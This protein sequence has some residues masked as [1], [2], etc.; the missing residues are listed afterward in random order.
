LSVLSLSFPPTPVAL[1]P[2]PFLL[3]KRNARLPKIFL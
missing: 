3:K 2:L 1:V